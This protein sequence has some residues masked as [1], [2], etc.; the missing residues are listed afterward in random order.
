M[1]FIIIKIRKLFI[2]VA[3]E[4]EIIGYKKLFLVLFY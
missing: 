2:K 1:I 3:L 4:K